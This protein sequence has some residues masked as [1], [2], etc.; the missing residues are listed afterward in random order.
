ME[1][2]HDLLDLICL[3]CDRD[4]VQ[5]GG[6]QTEDTVSRPRAKPQGHG[7]RQK[8]ESKPQTCSGYMVED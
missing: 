4:P 2:T 1:T 7:Q 6:P 3:Y 8:K 5:D